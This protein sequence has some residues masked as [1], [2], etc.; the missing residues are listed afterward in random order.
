MEIIVLLKQVPSTESE[1]QIAE[2]GR[3]IQEHD[4]KWVI[5]PYD[6]FAVEEDEENFNLIFRPAMQVVG[7]IDKKSKAIS[8]QPLFEKAAPLFMRLANQS[9]SLQ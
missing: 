1:I 9:G 6:E 4:T 7:S 3:S 8:V 2:D 5:N